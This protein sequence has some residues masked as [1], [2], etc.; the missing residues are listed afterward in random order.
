MPM[1]GQSWLHSAS[2][3]LSMWDVMMAAMMLP[4]LLPV[5]W[6]FRRAA[7]DTG[8]TRRNVLTAL[9]AC[10]Y[11]VVWTTF[12]MVLCL[13]GIAFGAVELQLPGLRRAA[14][15]AIG[16]L[17]IMVALH[18]LSTSKAHHLACSRAVSCAR[19][20][21]AR[22]G[23]ALLLG[24]RLGAHCVCDCGP[25]MALL[26]LF[27]AMDLRTMALVTVA[28]TVERIA[29]AESQPAIGAR[30]WLASPHWSQTRMS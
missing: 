18:Q 24:V 22:A 17:A 2:S 11:F 20:S 5:L 10:G 19:G 13:L 14:P 16:G 21:A 12:G 23:A 15:M 6:R 28:I 29:P 27:G 9:V 8:E 30:G 25:V 4:S 1:P 7:R 3:F 26:L